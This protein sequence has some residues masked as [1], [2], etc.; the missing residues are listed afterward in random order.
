[1]NE[2]LYRMLA[3]YKSYNLAGRLRHQLDR[4]RGASAVEYGL[5]I[6][7]VAGVIIVTVFALGGRLS[8][9]FHTTCDKMTSNPA[10]NTP[11]N[12]G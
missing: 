2:P 6:A 5:I 7:L 8:Q 4:D 10:S 1:M 12:C 3:W 11:N 9:Y